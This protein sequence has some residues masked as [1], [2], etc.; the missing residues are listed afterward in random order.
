MILLPRLPEQIGTVLND[1]FVEGVLLTCHLV[2]RLMLATQIEKND[3]KGK[4]I[5]GISLI[6]VIVE[7][8]WSYVHRRSNFSRIEACPFAPSNVGSK[9]ETDNFDLKVLIKN[10]IFWLQVYIG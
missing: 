7:N 6:L 9:S 4:Y 1:Q 8:L 5:T 10:N 2:E 3:G